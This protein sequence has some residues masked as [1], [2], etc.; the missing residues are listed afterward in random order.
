V[1]DEVIAL[2]TAQHEETMEVANNQTRLMELWTAED[3]VNNVRLR[4]IEE[5]LKKMLHTGTNL[6]TTCRE[7]LEELKR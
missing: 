4:M 7:L 1:S 3:R 2:L 5:V 6:S